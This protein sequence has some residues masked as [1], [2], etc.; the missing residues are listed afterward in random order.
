MRWLVVVGIVVAGLALAYPAGMAIGWTLAQL[1]R[2][3][4][5][6]FAR[7]RETLFPPKKAPTDVDLLVASVM[8]ESIPSWEQIEARDRPWR[9]VRYFIYGVLGLPVIAFL[10]LGVLMW[11]GVVK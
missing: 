4:V 2:F 1:R 6:T 11:L 3:A 7:W 5:W 9:R 10:L 8:R